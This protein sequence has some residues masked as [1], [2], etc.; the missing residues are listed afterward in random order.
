M[1]RLDFAILFLI[2]FSACQPVTHERKSQNDDRKLEQLS[3]LLGKW[4][5]EIPDGIVTEEWQKPSDTQWQGISYLITT[6]GDTPFYENIKLNY[7]NDT[8]Y[9]LPTIIGQNNDREVSFTEKSLSD[10]IIVF[11]NLQHDFPQRIIYKRLSD[12]SIVASVE[13]T[14]NGQQRKE[15][16]AYVRGK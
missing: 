6:S 7:S 9:Y 3:W 4:Q 16:F 15:E 1:K 14:Q 2:L 5:M 12:T 10:S 8:L 11:E 13:G